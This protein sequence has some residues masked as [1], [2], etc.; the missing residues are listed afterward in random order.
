MRL[1]LRGQAHAEWKILVS[2]DRRNVKDDQYFVDE[3]IIVW[4]HGNFNKHCYNT[5]FVRILNAQLILDSS[6]GPIPILPRG[7]HQFPFTFNLPES[8][9]PCSFESRTGYVRYYV[10]ATVD[11]PYAS[12]PQG[13]KYFTLIGPHIDCMDEQYLVIIFNY[14]KATINYKY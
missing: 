8:A 2:G 5:L 14:H 6:D 13:L 4:G 7:K 11:R 12:P 9:L 10:K 1:S 3:R